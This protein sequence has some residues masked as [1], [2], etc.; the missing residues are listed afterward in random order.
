MDEGKENNGLNRLLDLLTRLIP[1]ASV[2][3][4]LLYFVGRRYTEGYLNALGVPPH[5]LNYGVSDYMFQGAYPWRILIVL[6]FAYFGFLLFRYG[7]PKP[8]LW[9]GGGVKIEVK[10]IW[11]QAKKLKNSGRARPADI[12]MAIFMSIYFPFLVAVLVI[13]IIGFSTSKDYAKDASLILLITLSTFLALFFLADKSL[14]SIIRS[15]KLLAWPFFISAVIVFFMF[16]YIA[17]GAYGDVSGA[18]DGQSRNL[19]HAFQEVQLT[20]EKPIT[21]LHWEQEDNGLWI[22]TDKLYLVASSNDNLFLRHAGNDTWTVVIPT[23]DISSFSL[24]VP[25]LLPLGNNSLPKGNAT[26]P[27]VQP[28][29]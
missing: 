3:G 26:N 7:F 5:M 17:A 9:G 25:P 11:Y 14:M 29:P 19:G 15:S 2:F 21:G 1:I 4:A 16:P 23:K 8:S 24:S 22:T 10:R 27:T 12:F 13:F 20:I 6:I 28:F 18:I